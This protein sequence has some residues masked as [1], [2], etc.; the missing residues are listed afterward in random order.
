MQ[1][2][3]NYHAM[4]SIIFGDSPGNGEL[5]KNSTRMYELARK[6]TGY[7]SADSYSSG[8]SGGWGNLRRYLNK[9]VEIPSITIEIG[10]V[11]CPLPISSYKDIWKENQ[12]VVIQEAMLFL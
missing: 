11:A 8:T 10:R 2:V 12:T 4:G 7:S 3:V 6:I 9:G 5:A 1:G